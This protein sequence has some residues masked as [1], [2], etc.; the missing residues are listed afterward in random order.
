M[1][2][3]SRADLMRKAPSVFAEEQHESLSDRYTYIPTIRLIEALD[4][5][6]WKPVQALQSKARL[7]DHR[8]HTKHSVRFRHVAQ[9]NHRNSG[10]VPEIILFNSHDGSS[11]YQ[12]HAGIYRFLCCNGLIIADA[13]LSHQKI[14]HSGDVVG[15][16]IEGV[17]SIV[18]DLPQLPAKVEAMKAVELDEQEQLAFAKAAMHVRWEEPETCGFSPCQV[19]EPRR[20]EDTA[21][22]L[23]HTFNRAQENLLQGGLHGRRIDKNGR[24]RRT[25]TRPVKA[26]AEDLK[27][28]KALWALAEEMAALKRR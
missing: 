26:P 3:M 11:S 17:Y 9:L 25:T 4:V 18:E 24:S 8:E 28:N 15:Q 23:W 1:Y 16:V 12:I 13:T 22:D 10:M 20:L 2:E 27:I 19:I 14:R 21:G 6:G 7:P 5:E